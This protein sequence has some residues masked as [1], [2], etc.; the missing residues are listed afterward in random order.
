[1]RPIIQRLSTA[2]KA[3][4]IKFM[5][6][7]PTLLFL[8]VVSFELD[9]FLGLSFCPCVDSYHPCDLSKY[10]SHIYNG[11]T[12]NKSFHYPLHCGLVLEIRI[13]PLLFQLSII[14]ISIHPTIRLSRLVLTRA[15][16]FNVTFLSTSVA[17]HLRHILLT[18]L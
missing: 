2:K 4:S 17:G 15:M 13:I 6:K 9:V 11:G 10:R 14:Q 16:L 12:N 7:S 18:K 5:T 8:S 1:M 3:P